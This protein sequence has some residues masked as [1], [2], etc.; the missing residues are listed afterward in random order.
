MSLLGVFNDWE[1]FIVKKTILVLVGKQNQLT[2]KTII[3][4]SVGKMRII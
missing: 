2:V 4:V 3:L 1:Q